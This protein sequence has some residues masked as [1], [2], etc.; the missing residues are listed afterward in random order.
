MYKIY[1]QNIAKT[2]WLRLLEIKG[3]KIET[4]KEVRSIK[5]FGHMAIN[6]LSIE[7]KS[8]LR[9]FIENEKKEI[10]KCGGLK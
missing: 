8:N 1:A 6:D 9:L 5:R 10:T 3:N 7:D 4:L 2:N